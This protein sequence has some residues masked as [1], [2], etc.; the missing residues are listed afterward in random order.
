MGMTDEELRESARNNYAAQMEML[1]YQT[2]GNP[3]EQDAVEP[4][5]SGIPGVLLCGACKCSV[6]RE[7]GYRFRHCPWCGKKVKWDG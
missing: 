2:D 4:V 1:G 3:K 6:M 7:E 5:E